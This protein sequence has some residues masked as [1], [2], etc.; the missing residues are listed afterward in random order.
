MPLRTIVWTHILRLTQCDRDLRELERLKLKRIFIAAISRYK[1]VLFSFM[2]KKAQETCF[3]NHDLRR[4]LSRVLVNLHVGHLLAGQSVS[5]LNSHG[6]HNFM[7][8]CFRKPVCQATHFVKS[9]CQPAHD[10]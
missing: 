4:D 8:Q 1:A 5:W 7:H 10:Q 6:L 9:L 2:A 3:M